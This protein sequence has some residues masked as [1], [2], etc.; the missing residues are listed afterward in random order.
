M[1]LARDPQLHEKPQQ[2]HTESE[3][4]RHV[5]RAEMD[6]M[7]VGRKTYEPIVIITT[8]NRQLL[9]LTF[10]VEGIWAQTALYLPSFSYIESSCF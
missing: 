10:D 7:Q 6:F 4:S 8:Q 2:R 9:N 3:E 5:I 1:F